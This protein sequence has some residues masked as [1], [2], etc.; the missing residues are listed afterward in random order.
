MTPRAPTPK[1]AG[2]HGKCA[3]TSNLAN[4]T[5]STRRLRMGASGTDTHWG[6]DAVDAMR[7][8][9]RPLGLV[10]RMMTRWPSRCSASSPPCCRRYQLSPPPSASGSWLSGEVIVDTT[11]RPAGL[12]AEAGGAVLRRAGRDV[13]ATLVPLAEA[14]RR[15][16]ASPARA[17]GRAAGARPEPPVRRAQRAG[18]G[19][20]PWLT[21]RGAG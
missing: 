11:A 3:R 17:R 6:P 4:R 7:A 12:G 5:F 14:A 19:P 9:Q 8:E 15:R 10:R 1:L 2:R 18:R 21:R 20:R 13:T 16:R